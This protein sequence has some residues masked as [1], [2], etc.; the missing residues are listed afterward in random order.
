MALFG[1]KK[2]TNTGAIE[3]SVP[4]VV[5]ERGDVEKANQLIEQFQQAVGNDA[6]IR[7]AGL[8]IAMAGG[9]PSSI[10]EAMKNKERTGSQGL[11]RPWL[12]LAEVDKE[13]HREGNDSLVARISLFI[14]FWMLTIEPNLGLGDRMDMWLDPPPSE[15]LVTLYSTALRVLPALDPDEVIADSPTGSVTV[16]TVLL[17]CAQE[18]LKH[19]SELEPEVAALAHQALR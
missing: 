10:S 5:L 18:S 11:D 17:G 6:A 4:P 8:A 1:K 9:A 19:E 16:Q 14:L 13:A 7:A 12:W 3:L 2:P 15:A